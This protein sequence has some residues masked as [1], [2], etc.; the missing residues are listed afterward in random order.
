MDSC[1]GENYSCHWEVKPEL[2]RLCRNEIGCRIT[3]R[4]VN[5]PSYDL[6]ARNLASSISSDD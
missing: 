2:E 4:D 3:P 6:D 1:C 5:I